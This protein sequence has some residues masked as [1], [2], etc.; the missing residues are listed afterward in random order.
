MQNVIDL[1]STELLSEDNLFSQN[2]HLLREFSFQSDADE[3]TA[4]IFPLQWFREAENSF[5]EKKTGVLR[6]VRPVTLSNKVMHNDEVMSLK[7]E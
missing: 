1:L 4:K 7:N 6:N 3:I 5:K 2:N